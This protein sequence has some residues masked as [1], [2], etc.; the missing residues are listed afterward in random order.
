MGAGS[1]AT[2]Q[3]ESEIG[4]DSP[5]FSSLDLW[6]SDHKTAEEQCCID[7]DFVEYVLGAE[8]NHILLDFLKQFLFLRSSE[9]THAD[10]SLWLT[11]FQSIEGMFLSLAP[12]D[13]I[14]LTE[15]AEHIVESA[16]SSVSS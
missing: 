3:N 15:T 14:R 16:L 2:E 5:D 1:S 13:S 4:Q 8:N 11:T 7:F 10:Y 6:F 9:F 12:D